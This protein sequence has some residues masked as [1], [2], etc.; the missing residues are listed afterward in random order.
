ME[1]LYPIVKYAK[2]C[3]GHKLSENELGMKMYYCPKCNRRLH[4][5]RVDPNDH[6][7]LRCSTPRE[8]KP[9]YCQQCG[10]LIHPL[11]TNETTQN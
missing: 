4:G 1:K 5:E 11:P 2:T 3:L 9:I 10:S 6:R 7:N 8:L